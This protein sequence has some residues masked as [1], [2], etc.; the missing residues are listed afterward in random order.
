MYVPIHNL[1]YCK[2]FFVFFKEFF[3]CIPSLFQYFTKTSCTERGYE[4]L[5]VYYKFD[6]L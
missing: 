4:C 1:Y 3:K 5:W 2:V 6:Q